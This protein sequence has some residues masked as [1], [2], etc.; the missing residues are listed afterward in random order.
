MNTIQARTEANKTNADNGSYGIC[1]VIDASRLPSP[2]PGHAFVKMTRL[3]LN[4]FVLLLML[5][6]GKRNEGGMENSHYETINDYGFEQVIAI[7]DAKGKVDLAVSKAFSNRS[8]EQFYEQREEAL[9]HYFEKKEKEFTA[10]M[11]LPQFKGGMEDEGFPENYINLFSIHADYLVIWVHNKTR[12]GL[13]IVQEDR[14]F[15]FV[16]TFRKFPD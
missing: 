4:L 16:V 7:A 10:M 5:S 3:L 9:N 11:G 15:P 1:R 12:Y 6:C 2:D 8:E 13:S 14:E